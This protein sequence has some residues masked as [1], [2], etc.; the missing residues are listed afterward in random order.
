[1]AANGKCCYM[2]VQ[3]YLETSPYKGIEILPFNMI[4]PKWEMYIPWTNISSQGEFISLG[5]L[6]QANHLGEKGIE[7]STIM[8][9]KAI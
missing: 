2:V 9:N 4:G 5:S 1:M 7:E 3:T 8:S 6:L